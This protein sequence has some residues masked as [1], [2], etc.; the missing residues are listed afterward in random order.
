MVNF[1]EKYLKYKTKYFELQKMI[2]GEP[3]FNIT[4]IDDDENKIVIDHLNFLKNFVRKV[5]MLIKLK[6]FT[7][8]FTDE[9]IQTIRDLNNE[10]INIISDNETKGIKIEDITKKINNQEMILLYNLIRSAFGV[11]YIKKEKISSP[12][13][14]NPVSLPKSLLPKPVVAEQRYNSFGIDIREILDGEGIKFLKQIGLNKGYYNFSSEQNQKRIKYIQN[15]LNTD[16]ESAIEIFND[17]K[18]K[19]IKNLRK[20]DKLIKSSPIKIEIVKDENIIENK[21]KGRNNMKIYNYNDKPYIFKTLKSYYKENEIVELKEIFDC[22]EFIHNCIDIYFLKNKGSF[23][24][25]FVKVLPRLM[26]VMEHDKVSFGYLMEI[27]PGETVR[28]LKKLGNEIPIG[29][30]QELIEELTDNNFLIIDFALDNIIW[31]NETHT[32]TYIDVNQSSFNRYE[33][34]HKYNDDIMY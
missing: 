22:Y 1:Y 28:E 30:I 13:V 33:E 25:Q 2:G 18:N 27:V 11:S 32:L 34:A 5:D 17:E 20:L 21:Y 7:N 12:I 23:N 29:A 24:I 14:S 8:G 6:D 31:D 15:Y 4:I 16:Y 10:F 26:V 3:Q 19:C 9:T